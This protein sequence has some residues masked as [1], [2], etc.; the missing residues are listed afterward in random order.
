MGRPSVNYDT[1][2]ARFSTARENVST[3]Y[4]DKVGAE[5]QKIND[6]NWDGAAHNN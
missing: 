6:I 3:K 4:R 5:I 2:S 1:A